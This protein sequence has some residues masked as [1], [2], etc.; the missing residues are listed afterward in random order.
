M[1][2]VI[3]G[4]A[5]SRC[6]MTPLQAGEIVLARSHPRPR[7]H[8][9]HG[10]DMPSASGWMRGQDCPGGSVGVDLSVAAAESWGECRAKIPS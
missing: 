9:L 10:G 2:L 4:L 3:I 5:R 6:H 7:G 8:R 1:P